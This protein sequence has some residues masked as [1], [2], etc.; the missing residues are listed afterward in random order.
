MFYG[1]R[2][3]PATRAFRVDWGVKVIGVSLE[4]GGC[5]QLVDGRGERRR[6]ALK[7][8]DSR[9]LMKTSWCRP[10]FFCSGKAVGPL[11]FG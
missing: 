4:D 6:A 5:D 8:P 2:L 1:L 7:Q 10:P 3:L 11:E 9:P